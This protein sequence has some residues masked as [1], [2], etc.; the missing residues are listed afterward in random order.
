MCSVEEAKKRMA[1]IQEKE[2]RERGGRG[3]GRGRRG[4]G[5]RERERE[6]ERGGREM[7][8]SLWMRA[9]M[10]LHLTIRMGPM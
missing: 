10:K 6:R 9:T 7:R 4:R 5:R 3:R 2:E 1:D 8:S